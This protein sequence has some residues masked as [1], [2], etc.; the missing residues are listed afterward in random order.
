M[1]TTFTTS[2]TIHH[3]RR[4]TLLSVAVVGALALGAGA[5]VGR[6]TSSDSSSGVAP[7]AAIA[8]RTSVDAAALWDQLATMSASERDNVVAGLN[9]SVRVRLQAI[10][11]ELATVAAH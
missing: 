5:A 9:P 3:A 10:G 6:V 8:A 11:Q 7:K 4:R 1:T 2:P